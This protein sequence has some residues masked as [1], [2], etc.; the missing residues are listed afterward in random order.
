MVG[1]ID[2]FAYV[3]HTYGRKLALLKLYFCLI[4]FLS[5]CVF[6]SCVITLEVNRVSDYFLIFLSTHAASVVSSTCPAFRQRHT[7]SSFLFW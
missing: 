6:G 5:L 7:P 1:C 2:V 3:R 4:Y